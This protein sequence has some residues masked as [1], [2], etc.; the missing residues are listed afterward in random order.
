M[1]TPEEFRLPP[2]NL[3]AERGVLGSILLL[4]EAIDEVG[5]VLRTEQFY[6]DAHQKIYDAI[7]H[8]YENNVRGIDGVTLAEELVRRGDLEDVGGPSYLAEI[9]DTVPHAAHVR[10]YAN[11]VREKWLQRSLIYA[12]TEILSESYELKTDVEDL[13]QDAERKVFSIVEQQEGGG[14]IAI[15]DILMDAFDRIEERLSQEGDVTGCTTGFQDLDAQTTGFQPTELIILAARPSMGK[16]AFVCNVAEAIA[17]DGKGV[18]LFSLEQSNLELVERFLCITARVNGHDLRAGN[19]TA[20]QRDQLMAASDDLNRLELFI[21]DKPGRTMAQVAA[22]ARRLHRKSPL[23]VIIIDYLQLIEPDDKGAPREQQIAGISRRLK[24]LAKEL[25]VPVIALAQLNRGVELREDKR[26]R[27]ADLRESGAI[28]QDADM[29]M[30]LHRPDAYDP[31]DRPGEAEIVVAKHRSGPTG[32]VRL[33]WR[34]EFMRF[35]NYSPLADT[36]FDL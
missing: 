36:D 33:T 16:T 14:K 7:R 6:S 9:L 29:V 17:R 31:E 8:L 32:I 24:F 21:D 26:P 10:Y 34:K 27:L 5:E 23:G 28:E 19:L 2:Q 22:L 13:L 15:S 4:N 11:I 1:P 25:R 30:F 35:E 20:E 3:D 18:L 12:C